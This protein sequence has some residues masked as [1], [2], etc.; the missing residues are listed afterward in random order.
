MSSN[1]FRVEV[2]YCG[3]YPFRNEVPLGCIS[4]LKY[5]RDVWTPVTTQDAIAIANHFQ[6]VAADPADT[7]NYG[8]WNVRVAPG[9]SGHDYAAARLDPAI[10]GAA[11][12]AQEMLDR[13][14]AAPAAA[15]APSADKKPKK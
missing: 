6:R 13:P 4:V 7:E 3:Q 11:E 8:Q 2:Q 10:L 12:H 1:N 9:T 14:A 5:E 15:D